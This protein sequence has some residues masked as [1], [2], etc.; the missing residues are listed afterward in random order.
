MPDFDLTGVDLGLSWSVFEA[1]RCVS[2]VYGA[3][4]TI[5]GARIESK[6][7]FLGLCYE[8]DAIMDDYQKCL[9]C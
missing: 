2:D 3:Y 5:V 6:K 1:T 4:G 7:S 9:R 8:C